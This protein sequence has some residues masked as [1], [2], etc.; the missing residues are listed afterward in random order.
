VNEPVVELSIVSKLTQGGKTEVSAFDRPKLHSLNRQVTPRR[1]LVESFGYP[2]VND[3]AA[4]H[5]IDVVGELATEIE[6]LLDEQDRHTGG[7]AQIADGPRPMSLM[8][9]G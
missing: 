5:D 6:I 8:I 2:L 9:D 7:I 3:F 1:R 4:V